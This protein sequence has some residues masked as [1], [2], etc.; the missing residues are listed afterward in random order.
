MRICSYFARV[1]YKEFNSNSVLEKCITLFWNKGF[2][3]CAISDIVEE[4]GVNR[5]SLYEAFDNKEG[6]LIAALELYY[7]RYGKP[8]LE[9]L[10]E[11]KPLQ[12]ALAAFYSSY[13]NEYKGRP[14]GCFIVHTATELA[15]ANV[16]VREMLD[17]YLNGI[18]EHI[19]VLLSHTPSLVESNVFYTR[20]LIGLFC[21][22]ISFCLIHNYDERVRL[23]ENGIRVIL[24][25]PA[26]HA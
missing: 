25:K 13:L 5:F 12:K 20:Q 9:Y 7:E 3:A 11:T 22:S 15:D 19:L 26:I 10:D 16:R 21:T 1:R 8:H 6:I 24:D 18:E 4:T 2:G 17:R 14:A 23:I